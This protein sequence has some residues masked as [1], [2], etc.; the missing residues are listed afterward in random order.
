MF[1]K[2]LLVQKKEKKYWSF[3]TW[4]ELRATNI[5]GHHGYS[6][7]NRAH[8]SDLLQWIVGL[9]NYPLCFWTGL[10]N[11][12]LS[13]QCTIEWLGCCSTHTVG[14]FFMNVELNCFNQLRSSV[15]E[16]PWQQPLDSKRLFN[17]EN[18]CL[19]IEIMCNDFSCKII[20]HKNNRS[21]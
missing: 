14:L 21:F 1:G 4:R 19:L 12:K 2:I 9:H 11:S 5:K 16:F 3:W 8:F 6:V 17:K 15:P 20:A 13:K 18:K 10:Q 7:P